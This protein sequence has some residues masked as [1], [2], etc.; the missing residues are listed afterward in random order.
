[1]VGDV[2]VEYLEHGTVQFVDLLH[3]P[4][5]LVGENGMYL[6]M[7]EKVIKKE[8]KKCLPV[9]EGETICA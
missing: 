1:M 4:M 3:D 7:V 9:C 2:M 5:D 8:R 6:Y